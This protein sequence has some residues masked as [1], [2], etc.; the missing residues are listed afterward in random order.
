MSTWRKSWTQSVTTFLSQNSLRVTFLKKT[1]LGLQPHDLMNNER[2]VIINNKK[3]YLFFILWTRETHKNRSQDRNSWALVTDPESHQRA[4]LITYADDTC[5]YTCG[6]SAAGVK[7]HWTGVWHHCP[8]RR[9]LDGLNIQ[10][11]RCFMLNVFMSICSSSGRPSTST[12]SDEPTVHLQSRFLESD[13]SAQC[14]TLTRVLT[15]MLKNKKKF[16]KK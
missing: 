8:W 14:W 12:K 4:C 15:N 16:F 13:T 2:C 10:V 3:M 5:V 1:K 6:T 7:H 9:R 11:R